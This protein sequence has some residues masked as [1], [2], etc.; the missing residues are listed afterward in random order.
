MRKIIMNEETEVKKVKVSSEGQLTIPKVFYDALGIDE[1]VT[2]EIIDGNLLI[3]PIH[4]LPEDFAEQLLESMMANGISGEEL[5]ERFK[6]AKCN[7]GFTTFSKIL[8]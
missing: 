6:K 7:A 8:E 3:K 4:K 2:I 5:Q 1:E